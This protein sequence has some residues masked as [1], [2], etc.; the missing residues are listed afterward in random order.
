MNPIPIFNQQSPEI[1]Y[2][3]MCPICHI[4]DMNENNS[5]TIKE[6]SHKFHIDCIISWLR[7]DHA[8]C[9]MCNGFQEPERFSYSG[10]SAFKLIMNFSRRKDAP[11]QLKKMTDKY[12]LL[13]QKAILARKK[14]T[15]FKRKNK[16]ILSDMR[17]LRHQRFISSR[18]V[19]SIKREISSIPIEPLRIDLKPTSFSMSGGR[20]FRRS[21]RNR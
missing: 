15:L 6:C 16:Q 7:T 5:Y 19:M 13:K 3:I 21:M 2:D 12:K 20:S 1:N 18:K 9:P 14:E 11:K 10:I 4:E 17:K 8:N